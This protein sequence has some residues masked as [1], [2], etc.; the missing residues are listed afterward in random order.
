MQNQAA[1]GGVDSQGSF[2]SPG[3]LGRAFGAAA[4]PLTY[5]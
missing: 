1:G 3:L 5:P 4:G 2:Q